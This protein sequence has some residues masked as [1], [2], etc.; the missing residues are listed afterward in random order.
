MQTAQRLESP[1]TTRV[2][3]FSPQ[4]EA[5]K[6]IWSQVLLAGMTRQSWPVAKESP[7]VLVK[8]PGPLTFSMQTESPFGSTPLMLKQ[9]VL[10]GHSRMVSLGKTTCGL[11]PRLTLTQTVSSSVELQFC[12]VA[13]KTKQYWPAAAGAK[14]TSQVGLTLK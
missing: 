9:R 13:R 2:S 3:S 7:Q 14:Q 8:L 4:L 11:L 5:L 10:P 6:T 12:S 1:Q